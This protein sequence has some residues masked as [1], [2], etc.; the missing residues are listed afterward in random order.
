[1]R[2]PY[3]NISY[4]YAIDLL[5]FPVLVIFLS[6]L[7][8]HYRKIRKGQER[9]KKSPGKEHSRFGPFFLESV[10]TKGILGT[11]IY[12]KFFTGLAH[13]LVFWGMATLSL[14]T[15]LVLGDVILKLPVFSGPFNRWFMSFGLDLAGISVLDGTHILS[16]E[17]AFPPGQAGH[18]QGTQRSFPD[19]GAPG[20]YY[21]YGFFDRSDAHKGIG[22]RPGILCRKLRLRTP[23]G[24]YPPVDFP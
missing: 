7:Y 20:R 3:W 23:A 10:L 5:A 21:S 16:C 12:R 8:N 11:R 1:M 9:F 14:G 2:V 15:L 22:A 24:R 4:G 17:E 19:G 6:G 18:S 13:G